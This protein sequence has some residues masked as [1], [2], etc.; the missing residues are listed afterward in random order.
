MVTPYYDMSTQQIFAVAWQSCWRCVGVDLSCVSI[1]L[2]TL[3]R[4][5]LDPPAAFS[6]RVS[7]GSPGRIR[8]NPSCTVTILPSVLRTVFGDGPGVKVM[9]ML[10]Q[11]PCELLE[12]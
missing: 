8:T 11:H 2:R 6:R 10:V 7:V 4:L 3:F 9:V 5:A 12:R 1:M